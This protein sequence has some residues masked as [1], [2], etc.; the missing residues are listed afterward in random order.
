MPRFWNNLHEVL[1]KS[2][3]WKATKK[4]LGSTKPKGLNR[5]CHGLVF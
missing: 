3:G 2:K 5:T 4:F 1:S